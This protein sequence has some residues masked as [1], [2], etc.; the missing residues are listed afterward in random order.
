[1]NEGPSK[2]FKNMFIK[3]KQNWKKNH[4]KTLEQILKFII[5]NLII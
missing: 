1:M 3:Q 2:D 4:F 5:W